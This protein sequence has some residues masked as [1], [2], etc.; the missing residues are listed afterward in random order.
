MTSLIDELRND[1]QRFRRYLIWFSEEVSKLGSAGSPDYLLLNMLSTYFA[2]YPDEIHHKKE[3]ILYAHLVK[4]AKCNRVPLENLQEQHH[5]LSIRANTFSRIVGAIINN[6]Q[7]PVAEIASEAYSYSRLLSSHMIREEEILFR[8]SLKLL[9]RDVWWNVD[10][11]IGDLLA[12][13]VNYEKTRSV[14]AI[15]HSLEQYVHDRAG[16]PTSVEN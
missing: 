11:E 4:R 2:D 3:D 7:L 13:D 5:D 14:L 1:H 15:E 10:Q 6:E 16:S 9:S 12:D 8:P